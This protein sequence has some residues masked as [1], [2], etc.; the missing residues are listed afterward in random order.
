MPALRLFVG[1]IHEHHGDKHRETAN[2]RV[3]DIQQDA[4]L[5]KQ[6]P[7]KARHKSRN[8]EAEPCNRE[9]AEDW[10]QNNEGKTDREGEEKLRAGSIGRPLER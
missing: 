4:G 10:R 9:R 6:I 1:I 7:G 8:G 3:N 2:Q 5:G